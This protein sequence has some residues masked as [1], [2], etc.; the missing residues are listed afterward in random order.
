MALRRISNRTNRGFSLIEIIVVMGIIAIIG[1]FS[2]YFGLDSFRSYSFH[3]DRDLLV[4]LLQHARSEAVGNICLGSGCDD[5]RP[6]GVAIQTN[7]FVLF[8][9]TSYATRD[10]AV[11]A[12]MA[13][14]AGFSYTGDSEI[15]FSQLSATTTGGTITVTE[16]SGRTS[17]ITIGTEGQIIW[18]N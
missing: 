18:T 9:G 15:V 8:Q 10:A 12:V 13:A 7:Q 5:G 2:L 11:D 14:N 1:G 6:H 3:S 17:T 4:S 16:P